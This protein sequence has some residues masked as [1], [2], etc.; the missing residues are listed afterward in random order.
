MLVFLLVCTE[1]WV[2][3]C[4]YI[5][6]EP[7]V[8]KSKCFS[9]VDT[10]MEKV[11]WRV[12]EL[13]VVVATLLMLPLFGGAASAIAPTGAGSSC[14][15]RCGNISVPYPFGVEHGCYLEAGFNLTCDRSHRPPR[16]FLGD[17][18]VQVL[19]ISIPNAT[20]RINS[21]VAKFPGG[22]NYNTTNT[23]GTWGGALGGEGGPYSLARMKNKLVASGCNVQ[24]L[25]EG[26]PNQTVSAC[27]AFCNK[28]VQGAILVY[29]G[30]HCSGIG[31]CQAEI[32]VPRSSYR[33][34]VTKMKGATTSF[35]IRYVWASIV[36]S[37][38][39]PGLQMLD[40]KTLPAVLEWRINHMRCHGNK[41]SPA[42][43]SSHSFCENTTNEFT[44]VGKEGHICH[45]AQGYQGNPYI[46]NGCSGT[47]FDPSRPTNRVI[48]AFSL[49]QITERIL[50]DSL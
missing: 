46:P 38:F 25:L 10:Q 43:R 5:R 21:I 27:S 11:T 29:V 9:L 4:I 48:L 37:E 16:L 23:H 6:R 44:T 12:R 26:D 24:F 33:F 2:D 1:T 3:V 42:C 17:G 22:A 7:G 39:N 34:E 41:S 36:E 28:N 8:K 49:L 31:C 40:P 13:A 20:V 19:D 35:Q 14:T 32:F 18:T 15:R 47:Y 50:G 30:G 45:C